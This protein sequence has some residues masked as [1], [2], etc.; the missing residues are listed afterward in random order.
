MADLQRPGE[1]RTLDKS[2]DYGVVIGDPKIGFD[3]DGAFFAHDESFVSIWAS[4]E[5]LANERVQR[6]QRLAKERALARQRDMIK[7]KQRILEQI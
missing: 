1:T 7:Q 2:R 6:E 5:Q 4:R 3:Q